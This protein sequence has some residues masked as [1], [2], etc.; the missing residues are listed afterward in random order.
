MYKRLLELLKL[1]KPRQ[2]ILQQCSCTTLREILN[3]KMIRITEERK[4]LKYNS[5]EDIEKM[6]EYET[7]KWVLSLLDVCQPVA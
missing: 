4:L 1:N 2:P 3:Q 7:C 5:I 6:Q